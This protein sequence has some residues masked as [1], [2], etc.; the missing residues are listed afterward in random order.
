M[1]D[2]AMVMRNNNRRSITLMLEGIPI[3]FLDDPGYAGIVAHP[4]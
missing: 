4:N 2:P 3:Q 1:R